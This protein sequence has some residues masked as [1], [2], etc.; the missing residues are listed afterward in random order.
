MEKK[1]EFTTHWT[2][3]TR[4]SVRSYS[5]TYG[6]L[7]EDVAKARS[8]HAKNPLAEVIRISESYVWNEPDPAPNGTLH[9][10]LVNFS[11]DWWTGFIQ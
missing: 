7:E 8:L 6:T 9:I 11:V 10:Q 5:R 1:H 2:T 3:R 4:Y